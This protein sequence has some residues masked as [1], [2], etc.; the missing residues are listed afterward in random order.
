M[1]KKWDFLIVIGIALIGIVVGSFIDLQIS[2][3]LYFPN[4]TF[5]VVFAGLGE[6]PGYAAF[7][8]VATLA[9]LLGIKSYHRWFQKVPLILFGA[10]GIVLSIYFQADHMVCVDGFNIPSLWYVGVIVAT[11]ISAVG[12]LFGIYVFKNSKAENLILYVVTLC[13]III[14]AILLVQGVKIIM[15]R[16]RFRFLISEEGSLEYFC[17]WWQRGHDVKIAFPDIASDEF[18]SFPSG[19]TNVGALLIPVVAYLP[20]MCEKIK[21][22]ARILFYGA[23][24]YTLVL[25]V[26]RITVAAHFLTDVSFGILFTALVYFAFDILFTKCKKP[27]QI[28]NTIFADKQSEPSK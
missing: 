19:H 7:S 12:V 4:N 2:Q 5:G 11:I 13:F 10:A 21:V 14:V 15:Q 8:F 28:V 22:N 1:V 17:S 23:F 16:P 26:S 25:A 20:T 27:A 9:L 24:V 6:A 18:K 3:H